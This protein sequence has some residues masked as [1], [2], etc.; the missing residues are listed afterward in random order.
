MDEIQIKI[1]Q[2]PIL[3]GLLACLRDA[4]LLVVCAPEFGHDEQVRAGDDA[5]F[6]CAS[7]P[8]A[9]FALIAVV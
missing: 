3:Q 6:D 7:D 5:V 2:S 1:V 8:V 4:L 9:A